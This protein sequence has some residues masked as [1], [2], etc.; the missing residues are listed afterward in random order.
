MT[1]CYFCKGPV[2]ESRVQ[3]TRERKGKTLVLEDVPAQVCQQCGEE[4]YR[5]WVLED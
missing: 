4:F 1:Q 3:V 5:G 2:K